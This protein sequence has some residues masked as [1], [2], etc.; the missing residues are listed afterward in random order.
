MSFRPGSTPL[1]NRSATFG[2]LS[3]SSGSLFYSAFTFFRLFD[4]YLSILHYRL[5]LE[6]HCP[7]TERPCLHRLLSRLRATRQ[8]DLFRSCARHI[9]FVLHLASQCTG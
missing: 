8:A 7:S 1:L 5:G 3:M 6:F 2:T 9:S 4:D